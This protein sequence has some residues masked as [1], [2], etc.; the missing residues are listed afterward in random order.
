MWR[1]K[2]KMIFCDLQ[3]LDA[4][5]F[6][7]S[8]VK[9][10]NSALASDIFRSMLDKSYC[11]LWSEDN[12]KIYSPT[13]SKTK[14]TIWFFLPPERPFIIKS[15]PLMQLLLLRSGS[16]QSTMA[17]NNQEFRVG[18]SFHLLLRLHCSFVCLLLLFRSAAQLCSLACSLAHLL[19]PSLVWKWIIIWLFLLFFSVLDHSAKADIRRQFRS[20]RG[21]PPM[22]LALEAVAT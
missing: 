3:I 14:L 13:R 2:I 9:P 18:Q 12:W 10:F 22:R 7:L 4:I 6:E 16:T 17:Q 1:D 8:T 21:N 19:M 11:I 5:T 15:R 20:F